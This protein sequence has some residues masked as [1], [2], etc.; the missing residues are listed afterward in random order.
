MV[1]LTGH[2]TSQH[3]HINKLVAYRGMLLFSSTYLDLIVM[4]N[5]VYRVFYLI[6]NLIFNLIENT[7]TKM[8]ASLDSVVK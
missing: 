4:G 8:S 7:K 6:I 5:S 1:Y 2:F 3:I